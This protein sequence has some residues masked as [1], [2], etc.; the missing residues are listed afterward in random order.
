VKATVDSLCRGAQGRAGR[1]SAR[2]LDGWCREPATVAAQTEAHAARLPR[3]Q[4]GVWRWW[5][6]WIRQSGKAEIRRE[7]FGRKEPRERRV[8][9]AA[10]EGRAWPVAC[11]GQLTGHG[12]AS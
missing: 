12:G 9:V 7:D 4:A 3:A 5:R 8:D 1:S 2:R 11:G 10:G 6:Y